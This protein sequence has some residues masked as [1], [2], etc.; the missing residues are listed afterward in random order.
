MGGIADEGEALA[1]E[2]A[3]DLE[4]EGIGGGRVEDRDRAE[5]VAEA[6]LQLVLEELARQAA[7]P[8]GSARL[9]GPDD[10]GG[11]RRAAAGWRRAGGE[12]ML[13]G[14]ALV[15]IFVFHRADDAGLS[16]V[17]AD[18]ADAGHVADARAPAV[19]G[20]QQRRG[21]DLAIRQRHA[22]EPPSASKPVT[23]EAIIRRQLLRPLPQRAGDRGVGRHMGEGFARCDFAGEGE[24]DRSHH[25]QRAAVGHH[26]VEDRLG[27][28]AMASQTPVASNMRRAAAA[29]AEARPWSAA[30]P[31]WRGRPR[32][33]RS[34]CR[35]P[36]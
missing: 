25:V 3:R 18:G 13:L 10:G 34:P 4:F 32:G 29:K 20:H 8:F 36:S 23:E 1:D 27:L 6:G 5:L 35:V 22:G 14:A 33:T 7:Q 9:L 12:E 17:P 19:A 28:G 31:R 30:A 11:R 24:E 21:D 15:V 26:H 2:V 16:I